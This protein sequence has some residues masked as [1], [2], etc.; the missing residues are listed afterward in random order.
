MSLERD[1]RVPEQTQVRQG[2]PWS[3]AGHTDPPCPAASLG[4]CS[5]A[6]PMLGVSAPS[7]CPARA[8][9]TQCVPVLPAHCASLM[10]SPKHCFP[11]YLKTKGI[12]GSMARALF[13][14]PK[15]RQRTRAPVCRQLFCCPSLPSL[16]LLGQGTFSPLAHTSTNALAGCAASLGA[17]V[18]PLT[19]DVHHP[20]HKLRIPKANKHRVWRRQDL[21]CV[22]EI[23]GLVRVE[24]MDL[25]RFLRSL[26]P[27]PLILPSWAL[28]EPRAELTSARSA[29]PSLSRIVKL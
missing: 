3:S 23:G 5:S 13:M 10:H 15:I 18:S 7:R 28:V 4:S 19:S 8:G 29:S 26:Q 24:D 17:S 22:L 11:L 6:A 27:G 1:P 14:H 21:L 12:L 16:A 20:R 9:V 2:Q 25:Q